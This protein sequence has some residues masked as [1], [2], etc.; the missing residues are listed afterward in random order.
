LNGTIL[1]RSLDYFR[2]LEAAEGIGVGDAFEGAEIQDITGDFSTLSAEEV[3]RKFAN[4]SPFMKLVSAQPTPRIRFEQCKALRLDN[5]YIFSFCWGTIS[6]LIKAFGPR[7]SAKYD[8]CVKIAD[9]L[10]FCESIWQD[11]EISLDGQP[12]P[13]RDCFAE[14]TLKCM[15]YEERA[16][17]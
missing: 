14:P 7:S 4:L 9:P 3:Q 16:P 10:Q 1:V 13:F 6:E 2:I 15:A 11:G 17:K 12:F 5:H 8:A